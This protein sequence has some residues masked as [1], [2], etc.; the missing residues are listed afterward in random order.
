MNPDNRTL[1]FNDIVG[2]TDTIVNIDFDSSSEEYN[3]YC[4]SVRFGNEYTIA[5]DC[6][7]AIEIFCG[8]Y[9]NGNHITCP[10][11]AEG[12]IEAATYAKHSTNIFVHPFV[13]DKLTKVTPCYSHEKNLR[14]FIKVP[15][16]CTSSIVVMEGNYIKD[17]EMYIKGDNR[18]LKQVLCGD[19]L[20]YIGNEIFDNRGYLSKRQLL[21]YSTKGKFLLADRLVEY[22]TNQVIS[23]IDTTTNN[24]K[25]AQSQILNL[26]D[27]GVGTVIAPDGKE[28]SY[29][30]GRP[31]DFYGIWDDKTTNAIY[32]FARLA[33]F[34]DNY[35]D[36]LYYV[37]KDIETNMGG[38]PINIDTVDWSN[39]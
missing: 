1:E 14:M 17:T 31:F 15:V 29:S 36:L 22:L 21:S 35:K 7:S 38:L 26:N 12:E 11:F 9:D 33:G 34:R 25:R 4:L 3:V 24:V 10:K 39:K 13:Y 30:L 19:T 6:S 8:F 2:A 16:G 18:A 32:D 28:Y 23:P 37:D 27:K 5:I 20:K